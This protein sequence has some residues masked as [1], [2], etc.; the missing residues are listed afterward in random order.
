MALTDQQKIQIQANIRKLD[1]L[2][3]TGVLNGGR[4][5]L[6][7]ELY[8]FISAGGVGHKALSELKRTI[9][10]EVDSEDIKK[11]VMFFAVDTAIQEMDN[12]VEGE[13]FTNDEIMKI[14][15]DG[16]H[17]SINPRMMLKQFDSW[18]N[19]QLW[20]ETG[21][22]GSNSK[23]FGGTGAGAMRQCGRV[24]FAQS[25]AQEMLEKKLSGISNMA[26]QMGADAPVSKIQI[27]FLTGISGGTG[28]GTIVDLAFLTRHYLKNILGNIMH[29][30][31]F[32]AYLF[33]PSACSDAQ[34]SAQEAVNGNRNAY[35]ALKEI[36]YFMTLTDRNEH[37]TMDYGTVSAANVEV[38]DNIFDFCTLVEGVGEGGHFLLNKA[39]TAREIASLSILNII[40]ADNANTKGKEEV[41]LVDSFLSNTTQQAKSKISSHSDSQWPREANYHYSVIGYAA[42]V[43]P[44]DLL[45]VYAA[46]KVFDEVFSKFR[47]AE[48]ANEDAAAV[49]LSDC[50]LDIDSLSKKYKNYQPSQ[51]RQDV[52]AQSDAYFKAYG[53]YYM[54]NL[55]KAAYDLILNAPANYKH[56]ALGKQSG[57][58]ADRQKW[59]IIER[60]Y[61]VA[62]EELLT[63]NDQLYTVYTYVIKTLQ[64]LLENNAKLLTETSERNEIFGKSFYWSPID[65]TNGS[66]ATIAVT[67]YLDDIMNPQ[68]TKKLAAKFVQDLCE[69]KEKW[70]GLQK[71]QGKGTISFDAAKEVRDFISENLTTVI[72]TTLESFIVKAYSGNK[73]AQVST[74]DDQNNE[75]YSRETREA[76]DTI[77]K[78]LSTNAVALVST[79]NTFHLSECYKTAYLTLPA[80]CKWLRKA[81]EDLSSTYGI[82]RGDIYGSSTEDSMV[83][84]N[85]FADVP[86]WGLYW[87]SGA[88]DAYEGSNGPQAVGLHI[89]QSPRGRNW[90][91][92][93]NLLPR[94]KWTEMQKEKRQRENA[95]WDDIQ[96]K[97]QKMLEL[98][99]LKKDLQDDVFYDISFFET[100]ENGDE[101]FSEAELNKN[102]RYSMQEFLSVL[103]DKRKLSTK[104]VEFTNMIM[105]TTDKF[106]NSNEEEEFHFKMACNVIRKKM[107]D[108]QRL[109]ETIRKVEELEPILQNHNNAV[110]DISSLLNFI[111]AIKWELL[112]FNS[113]KRQWIGKPEDIEIVVGSPLGDK[114]EQQCAH[115]FGYRAFINADQDSQNEYVEKVKAIE[116]NATD[117]E[118]D[119][120]DER[121]K[122]LKKSLTALVKASKKSDKPWPEGSPFTTANE[123][124]WPMA[125]LDFE[126]RASMSGYDATAIRKFY[127][128][129]TANM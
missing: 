129:L 81:V 100:K 68:E 65:L 92:M 30:V 79:T 4:K 52:K 91:D 82:D 116:K 21:G 118:L 126:E 62:S 113:R 11:Q 70:T 90:A 15:F 35:A 42:C 57:L 46:K 26:A 6:A 89:E 105:N 77:L 72:N 67:Q 88:E 73:D 115:Y 120:A 40:C 51:M 108:R 75:I 55:T 1:Y 50:G 58:F 5:H 98:G 84:C 45:T 123:S 61:D 101:L 13:E 110:I 71:E 87:T 80:R 14:P 86:A 10:R 66:N 112:T 54:V 27:F 53:P 103:L 8:V 125:T 7:K 9:V 18:V 44:I 20:A 43:V 97:M 122:V 63:M 29:K 47:N 34:V 94:G 19:P 17:D 93:P 76:A 48:A 121:I 28:S 95:I 106:E 33:L 69:Q 83:L 124:A 39:R 104:K 2:E 56:K 74:Y 102:N 24:L 36:D 22:E 114:L 111:N 32:S 78:R 127:N 3:G 117:D 41:F 107:D 16:A 12:C 38:S 119:A 49:F 85:L 128:E 31:S 25:A 37:F 59:E 64:D 23:F 109:N 96:K 60:I 99:L